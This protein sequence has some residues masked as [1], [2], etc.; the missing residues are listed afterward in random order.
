MVGSLFRKQAVALC[1]F[2]YVVFAGIAVQDLRIRTVK[3]KTALKQATSSATV[4]AFFFVVI[5]ALTLKFPTAY[6]IIPLAI[7]AVYFLMEVRIIYN[8]RRT[9][10]QDP[11][12]LDQQLKD[13]QGRPI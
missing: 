3:N 6:T 11:S 13:K 5:L 9:A 7:L 2:G 8:I 12:Y 1:N 10:K 4:T